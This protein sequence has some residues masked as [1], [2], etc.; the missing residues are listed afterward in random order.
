MP[1][2]SVFTG[3]IVWIILELAYQLTKEKPLTSHGSAHW[4]AADEIK[5][6]LKKDGVPVGKLDGKLIRLK[7]YHLITCAPTRSGKGVGAILPTLLDYKDSLICLDL[8][9]ENYAITARF[10]KRF[11]QVFVINPFEVLGIKSSSYN[12]LDSIDLTKKD[13]IEKAGNIASLLIGRTSANSEIS[14]FDDQA[15]RLLQAVILFVCADPPESRNI[16]T[17]SDLIHTF[18]IE[19]L[20]NMMIARGDKVPDVVIKTGMQFLNNKNERELGSILST[21]QK[22]TNFLDNPSIRETLEKTNF[23]ISELPF[24]CMSIYLIMPQDKVGDFQAYIRIFFQLALSSVIAAEGKGKYEVLFLLDEIAQLGYVKSLAD[25]VGFIRGIGGQL[26]FFFQDRNQ[27]KS[28]YG[29]QADSIL[30]NCVKTFFGC[31]DLETAK[32]IS[33]TLD[34]ETVRVYDKENK[35]SN[36]IGRYLLTPGEVM[37]LSKK[38]LIIFIPNKPPILSTRLTYYK[39]KLFDG[40]WDDNPYRNNK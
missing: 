37:N 4:A 6:F 21:A 40:L 11:S 34:K 14:H 10:R 23:N 3:L 15:T 32:Y 36:L 22:A 39:E 1:L 17:V 28:I 8:K 33:E 2:I 13:C 26:W 24:K 35:R 12:W 38:K 27:L 7:D 30:A 25:A 31:N 18:S 16:C 9:G 5:E 20:C 19:D 29:N